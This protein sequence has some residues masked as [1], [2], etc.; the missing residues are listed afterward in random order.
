MMPSSVDQVR[1]ANALLITIP[2]DIVAA[3]VKSI[4][5]RI[6]RHLTYDPGIK[7]IP[8]SVPVARSRYLFR[9]TRNSNSLYS[10]PPC[11]R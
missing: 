6:R 4:F 1:L 8:Y 5:S 10:E 3:F 7:A 11:L 9:C 2:V